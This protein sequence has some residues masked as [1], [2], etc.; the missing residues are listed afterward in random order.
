MYNSGPSDAYCWIGLNDIDNEGTFVWADGNNSTYR[1]WYPG[2]PNS[3]YSGYYQDCGHTTAS[4]NW[5]EST[6]TYVASCYFCSG[7]GEYLLLIFHDSETNEY[8]HT[9]NNRILTE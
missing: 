8:E 9:Y 7:T 3:N 1:D 6:C 4:P 2:R 5:Y